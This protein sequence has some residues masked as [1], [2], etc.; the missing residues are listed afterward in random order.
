M[1]VSVLARHIL[2]L[3]VRCILQ[4]EK[5]Y[6]VS[7]HLKSSNVF[8]LKDDLIRYPCS[9][10]STFPLSLFKL[11]LHLLSVSFC[12]TRMPDSFL[13][14]HFPTSCYFKHPGICSSLL[15]MTQ[16]QCH[17]LRQANVTLLHSAAFSGGIFL[18]WGLGV[19][20][21]SLCLCA[22]FPRDTFLR[23]AALMS[24]PQSILG[25]ELYLVE[26]KRISVWNSGINKSQFIMI[27]LHERSD[28][29]M[30]RLNK[31]THRALVVF[32]YNAAPLSSAQLSHWPLQLPLSLRA[33]FF[34]A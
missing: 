13:R 26:S 23:R 11:H 6:C 33:T 32:S 3:V 17:S 21:V 20:S 19:F 16:S 4:M 2:Y 5:F 22:F 30:R 28:T 1:S 31:E 8:L 15:S 34:S 7:S 18:R 27:C 24:A 29:I 14:W 25:S 10:G 12:V 9:P